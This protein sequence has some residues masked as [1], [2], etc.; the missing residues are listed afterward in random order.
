MHKISFIL[1]LK[2]TFFLFYIIIFIK[3][4]HQFIYFTRYFNKIF[5]LLNFFI[6]SHNCLA[7][8]HALSLS[9]SLYSFFLNWTP[10]SLSVSLFSTFSHSFSKT[11]N[12]DHFFTESFLHRQIQILSSLA[13]PW[14][15][16][17]DPDP[18]FTGW[19]TNQAPRPRSLLHRPIHEL[20]SISTDLSLCW[21]VCVGLFVGVFLCWFVCVD[22]F[23][24]GCVC[25]HLRKRR[26]GVEVIV[27]GEE[28]EKLVRRKLI[29]N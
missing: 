11:T 4:S 12:P 2:L 5:I 8:I 25:V 3:H 22:V 29:K 26:W 27:H 13:D 7:Y 16:L 9:L 14:T 15:K 1:Y 23:V 19:S 10:L 20:S 28:R 24:Y 21:F 17:H 18:F 6:I